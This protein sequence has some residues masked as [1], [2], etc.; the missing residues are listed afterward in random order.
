MPA[1]WAGPCLS[2]AAP[3]WA[4]RNFVLGG[5]DTARVQLHPGQ[6]LILGRSLHL[7]EA[8]FLGL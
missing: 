8:R 3:W 2:W 7:S 6:L 1:F 4:G 5:H